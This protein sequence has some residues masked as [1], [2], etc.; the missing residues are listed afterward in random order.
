MTDKPLPIY[1]ASGSAQP[2]T[3]GGNAAVVEGP[4]PAPSSASTTISAVSP[5]SQKPDARNIRI[6][7]LGDANTPIVMMFG[8]ANSGK[9]VAL[10]RLA[11]F[12]SDKYG[13]VIADRAFRDDE[14][15][16]QV[17]C[18]EF[19]AFLT[20]V[21]PNRPIN[22]PDAD[23]AAVDFQ[24]RGTTEGRMCKFVEVPGEHLFNPQRPDND[25]TTHPYLYEICTHPARKIILITI[26]LVDPRQNAAGALTDPEFLRYCAVIQRFF[27]TSLNPKRDRMIFVITK[28]D[29]QT[30]MI[31][32]SV[33][34]NVTAFRR[35]LMARPGFAAVE[36]TLRRQRHGIK[37]VPFSAGRVVPSA[38]GSPDAF[39]FGDDAWPQRLWDELSGE[40]RGTGFFGSVKKYI[41]S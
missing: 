16:K 18:E 21:R 1:G 12:F 28:A 40:I 2:G 7:S 3:Q 19:Q 15:Y 31:G 35:A 38:P 32:N 11:K 4:N 26:P 33:Q 23:F 27:V 41:W 30:G 14:Y 5:H 17:L 13:E 9:T 36:S 8:P 10:L 22:T 29:E 6:A 24:E 39:I 37:V 20:Q 34:P 25:Q